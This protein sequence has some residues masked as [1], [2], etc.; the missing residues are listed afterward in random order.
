MLRIHFIIAHWPTMRGMLVG[1]WR[2]Q[3][4]PLL[5][6]VACGVEHIGVPCAGLSAVV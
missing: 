1:S 6:T 2:K 3:E 5:I 4:W